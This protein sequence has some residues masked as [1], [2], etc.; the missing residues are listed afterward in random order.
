[1]SE[2]EREKERERERERENEY[3]NDFFE[4]K[5]ANCNFCLHGVPWPCT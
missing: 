5:V 3:D 1:M 4:G 2:R